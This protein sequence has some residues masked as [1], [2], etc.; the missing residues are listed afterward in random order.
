MAYSKTKLEHV[1]KVFRE[2][3][4]GQ[5]KPQ[6]QRHLRDDYS[7]RQ[8]KTT[9]LNH[10]AAYQDDAESSADEYDPHAP[11]K[12]RSIGNGAKPAPKRVD[13][14]QP[15]FTTRGRTYDVVEGKDADA[16]FVTLKYNE[17]GSKAKLEELEEEYGEDTVDEP[18]GGLFMAAGGFGHAAELPPHERDRLHLK[19]LERLDLESAQIDNTNGR[20]LRNR[21]I[22]DR[23]PKID[24][25]AACKDAHARCSLKSNGQYPCTRCQ[26]KGFAC[27]GTNT[28]R[29]LAAEARDAHLDQNANEGGG[30]QTD[31]EP[32]LAANAAKSPPCVSPSTADAQ[33]IV[34]S[35]PDPYT[36]PPS[37]VETK[38]T[39]L[40]L[41]SAPRQ[42][43]ATD[44]SDTKRASQII[45]SHVH[46]QQYPFTTPVGGTKINPIVID[47]PPGSPHPSQSS[48]DGKLL[49]IKTYWAHPIDFKLNP[50]R[51]ETCHFCSDFRFGIYGYGQLEVEVIR[52]PGTGGLEETGDGHRARGKEATRMCVLCALARL[53][54]S[55][56]GVHRFRKMDIVLSQKYLDLYSEQLLAESWDP[57][58]KK[59]AYSTCSLCP[60]PASWSCCADKTHDAYRRKL[61]PAAGKDRG[62]GLL[63]CN[64]CHVKVVTDGGR[65][66]AKPVVPAE[67]GRVRADIEF[68]FPGSALHQAYR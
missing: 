3:E 29:M 52:F 55:K 36:T 43:Q 38:F 30:S 44:W 31:I 7:L 61:T 23:D 50:S 25:C 5:P 14:D 19:Y 62:C 37:S 24:K 27:V 57:P 18:Y 9:N 47:S 58:L 35:T 8:V 56:C 12:R 15:T 42:S 46:T 53:Y 41:S 17:E 68:L 26:K 13:P 33:S 21:K 10:A 22:P 28:D 60:Y 65:L 40:Q 39:K 4:L 67:K 6:S 49:R 54:I 51:T 59:G 16:A 48:G 34:E 45:R 11:T 20:A 64:D 32:F 66:K 2:A 1:I 63:L